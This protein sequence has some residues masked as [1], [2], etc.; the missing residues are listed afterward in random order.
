MN[1]KVPAKLRIENGNYV[2]DFQEQHIPISNIGW[3]SEDIE[4]ILD[5]LPRKYNPI[6]DD[7]LILIMEEDGDCYIETREF[8]NMADEWEGSAI[9]SYTVNEPIYTEKILLIK[10][11]MV[12]H[13]CNKGRNE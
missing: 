10:N 12:L 4:R 11:K 9:N 13:F 8:R 7:D 5:H 1:F 2:V 6:T 3:I